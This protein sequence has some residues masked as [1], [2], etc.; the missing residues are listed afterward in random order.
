VGGFW[1][2]YNTVGE[3]KTKKMSKEKKKKFGQLGNDVWGKVG[4]KRTEKKIPAR[5][6]HPI[7]GMWREF[8]GGNGD[9]NRKQ[10]QDT[11]H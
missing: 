1:K 7:G 10:A 4:E 9:E 11:R 6:L 2:L 5:K 8:G 3:K